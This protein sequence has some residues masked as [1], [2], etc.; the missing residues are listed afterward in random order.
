M[1][2]NVQKSEHTVGVRACMYAWSTNLQLHRCCFNDRS[3]GQTDEQNPHVRP[4]PV[5]INKNINTG[6]SMVLALQ[7]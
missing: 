1:E 6:K 4:P 2:T 3:S 7:T 5:N